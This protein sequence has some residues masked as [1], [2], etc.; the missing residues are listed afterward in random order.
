MAGEPKIVDAQFW[1][2]W[3][4]DYLS[5]AIDR[6]EAA[7]QRLITAISWFWTVYTVTALVGTALARSSLRNWEV[8]LV[9]SPIAVLLAS[10]LCALWALNPI[11]GSAHQTA[12]QAEELWRRILDRKL[13][14]LRAASASLGLSALLIVASG[15][16]VATSHSLAHG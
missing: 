1:T 5:G 8:V 4:A 14:R 10:Y 11:V 3:A 12:N 7:A 16:V 13:R 9:L 15:Y 6:R 2:D